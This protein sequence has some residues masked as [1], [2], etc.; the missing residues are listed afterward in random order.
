[1]M[2]TI[3]SQDLQPATRRDS[4]LPPRT[5]RSPRASVRPPLGALREV[6][7]RQNGPEVGAV[8]TTEGLYDKAALQWARRAPL[9]LSDFT[10]RPFVLA[11]CEPLASA[12]VLDLG[13][14]EG[15]VA[16]QIMARGP[17]RLV[18]MDISAGMIE[19]ARAAEAEAPLGIDY[20]VGTATDLSRFEPG[21]FDLVVAVFLFNYLSRD[22]TARTMREVARVLRPGGRFLFTVPH[23]LYPFLRGKE[24]PFY[25]AREEGGYFSA[26]D[27]LFEGRIWRR[28]GVALPVRCVHKTLSDYFGCLAEAGFR[29]LPEVHELSVTA[30][31]LALDPAFFGP[32][33][34]LP[35]HMA[36]HLER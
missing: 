29:S 7:A 16:R 32:L 26:R 11:R 15:Y 34:D 3:A 18:G 5:T 22:E 20:H 21:S 6:R 24:P 1:M 9:L 13:C 36:F 10:A 35:L 17:G 4:A 28:D 30:A 31:H 8:E 23:P 33:A 27:Q 14:G 2:T 19:K 12:R 25:F